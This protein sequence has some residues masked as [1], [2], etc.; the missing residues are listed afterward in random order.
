MSKTYKILLHFL[1]STGCDAFRSFLPFRHCHRQL[2]EEGI[3]LELA[4]DIGNLKD[5]RYD[6]CI[7][8]RHISSDFVPVVYALKTYSGSKIIWDLDDNLFEI[9]QS[10]PAYSAFKAVDHN[11]LKMYL[12]WSDFLT[13]STNTLATQLMEKYQADP[14]RI[15]VLPNLV[16][17]NDWPREKSACP[18]DKIHIIWA[19]SA[20]HQDDLELI[21]EPVQRILK[22]RDDVRFTFIGMIPQ[23]LL[24]EDPERIAF[25]YGCEVKYY[26]RYLSEFNPDISLAPVVD[27]D[28]NRAKS[29]IKWME[30]TLAGAATIASNIDPYSDVIRHNE[31]GLLVE[32]D[33][34]YDAMNKLISQPHE[35]KRLHNNARQSVEREHS[36]NSP[37][38]EKWMAFFRHIAYSSV[39]SGPQSDTSALPVEAST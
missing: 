17:L 22:E 28:F 6:A 4:R 21:K 7:F 31:T 9:P 39:A 2:A 16:D 19:G 5:N 25:Y 3:S 32:P 24:Q 8:H 33:E 36:W 29:G 11:V 26:S 12:A 1:T 20:T 38:Y 18:K 27:H 30:G 35:I 15:A 10:N 14:S 34:W 23:E 13:C 37:Q